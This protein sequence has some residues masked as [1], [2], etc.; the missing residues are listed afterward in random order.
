L[1][2]NCKIQTET[3]GAT[4]PRPASEAEDGEKMSLQMQY[5]DMEA[6]SMSHSTPL[7]ENVD[8][9]VHNNCLPD[10]IGDIFDEGAADGEGL[11]HF[12]SRP[13]EVANYTWNVGADVHE[14]VVPMASFLAN[15][16]VKNK[17]QNYN[18]VKSNF[19]VHLYIKATK[20]HGGALLVSLWPGGIE[21]LQNYLDD[22]LIYTRSQ[23]HHVDVNVGASTSAVI[24]VPF[25][26][27]ENY[28]DL[29]S[30]NTSATLL[31]CVHI[32]SYAQLRG[33]GTTDPI[34]IKVIIVPKN[35]TVMGPT[36]QA[37]DGESE[38]DLS[39]HTFE[40]C[41]RQHKHKGP[42]EYKKDGPVSSVATAVAAASGALGNLPIIGP[43]AL[44][45]QIGATAI[46]GI[47]QIFG[48]S[49]PAVISDPSLMRPIPL[50][51]LGLT[52]AKDTTNKLT[53]T[54]K[55]ELT[56]DPTTVGLDNTDEMAFDFLKKVESV[57]G[58]VEWDPTLATDAPICEWMVTPSMAKW[59][60]PSVGVYEILPTCL[61]WLA[62]PFT[63]WSGSIKYRVQIVGSQ[64]HNGKLAVYYDPYLDPTGATS[65][66]L[67]SEYYF[68]VDLSECRDF[69]FSIAWK[70]SV[71]YL[72]VQDNLNLLG[73]GPKNFDA[74]TVTNTTPSVFNGKI[75]LQVFNEL[76]VADGVT[77]VDI[78]VKMSAGED[79]ELKNYNHSN[80]YTISPNPWEGVDDASEF[81]LGNHVFEACASE[82]TD[83][84]T[85][86]AVQESKE[87]ALV[88]DD[89]IV[90][91]RRS[92][93]FYGEEIASLRPLLKRYTM[94]RTYRRAMSV[95]ST[96]ELR[97]SAYPLYP[98]YDS[99]GYDNLSGNPENFVGVSMLSYWQMAYSWWRGSIRY[100]IDSE[101]NR[102]TMIATRL[103]SKYETDDKGSWNVLPANSYAGP[104]DLL[105]MTLQLNTVGNGAALTRTNLN[106]VL[107]YEAP[108]Q[109][110]IRMSA[111][112]RQE[113]Y[114]SSGNQRYSTKEN[115][116]AYGD[117]VMVQVLPGTTED[118]AY[119]RQFVAAGEDFAFYGF[120]GAPKFYSYAMI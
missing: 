120:G 29:L 31:P 23:R 82:Q 4:G 36:L 64:L 44:A 11:E 109:Q 58:V 94:L 100:K 106:G 110:P 63:S 1:I 88:P 119:F 115:A 113:G 35:L 16:P 105:S 27:P 13:V 37:F 92:L 15:G 38:F 3:R 21:P 50:G 65:E 7:G 72:D 70:Q 39:Q 49:R 14:T 111:V 56:V 5:Y 52:D 75:R 41:A 22:E 40:A 18:Y 12:L 98:G 74:P 57:I 68:L 51:S 45:T 24:N 77:P 19:E 96:Y 78:I 53:L 60:Y 102:M 80:L 87:V 86:M 71:P 117:S 43:F 46:S 10:S 99:A 59:K 85:A 107:E 32:D 73:F 116:K 103:P 34:T 25:I 20:F 54:S 47:A 90:H 66:R 91:P 97:H 8:S 55:Q 26:W 118:P 17:L 76:V 108:Y 62:R 112:G 42:D 30:T 2:F 33:V 9:V 114:A 104:Q 93:V 69:T 79:F 67:N 28:Y 84:D 95:D 48:F 61:Y 89:P 6:C 83:Q 101:A 81:N